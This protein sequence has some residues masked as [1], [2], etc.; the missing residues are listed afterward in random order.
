[1]KLKYLSLND[2]LYHYVLECRSG[3][4]D[5][6]LEA[7]RRETESLGDEA[8]MQISREQ[9]SFLTVLTAAMGARSALEIGTFTGSSSICIARGLGEEGRLLCLDQ[10][11]EW[12]GLARKYWKLAGIEDRI[13]LRLGEALPLLDG[14]SAET[15]FDLVFIDADKTEYEAYY[16]RVLPRVR[17]NGLI[18]FDNMLWG[19]RVLERPYTEP[20]TAAID[21]FNHKLARDSRVET[22]LLPVADG[23]QFCRKK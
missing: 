22:V 15:V 10:S 8:R 6:V 7:L 19:G 18:L 1:M 12:T 5:P 16:E 21:A 4:A 3:A 17:T 2:P 14:L 20:D 11:R 9:G 23:L 13:E